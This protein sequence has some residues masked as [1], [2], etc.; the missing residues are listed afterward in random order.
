MMF[1]LRW[2]EMSYPIVSPR[3][4]IIVYSASYDLKTQKFGGDVG[5]IYLKLKNNFPGHILRVSALHEMG[6]YF[7]GTEPYNDIVERTYSFNSPSSAFLG[8]M[9]EFESSAWDMLTIYKNQMVS[10]TPV[11]I[12]TVQS[13]RLEPAVLSS[14]NTNIYATL[15]SDISGT[16]K[17]NL[18]ID[19]VMVALAI[20][21]V[22]SGTKEYFI[23]NLSVV[24]MSQGAHNICV[25]V[26]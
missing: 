23:T 5:F 25:E 22:E 7:L 19:G 16:V 18:F 10:V 2:L 17:L 26:A 4:Q 20:I 3:E 14:G 11:P 9:L 15:I 13:V 21:Q 6:A 1:A 24:G 8:V 12:V